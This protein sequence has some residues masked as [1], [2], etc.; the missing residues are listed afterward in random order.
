[1]TSPVKVKVAECQ[2]IGP[3]V[4]PVSL[5]ALFH[6]VRDFSVICVISRTSSILY[7]K[8]HIAKQQLQKTYSDRSNCLWIAI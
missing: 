4:Y 3:F 8:V 5:K 7:V 1:M 2:L 6:Q